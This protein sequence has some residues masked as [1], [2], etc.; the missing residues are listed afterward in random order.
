MTQMKVLRSIA[1]TTA[2]VVCSAF[3]APPPVEAGALILLD[4]EQSFLVKKNDGNNK[5]VIT[6]GSHSHSY[7]GGEKKAWPNSGEKESYTYDLI[8]DTDGKRA[9]T[10]FGEFSILKK[11]LVIRTIPTSKRQLLKT[12]MNIT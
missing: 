1:A 9:N 5:I 12:Y 3:N 7:S 2:V 4:K 8:K 6:N 10:H 11:R